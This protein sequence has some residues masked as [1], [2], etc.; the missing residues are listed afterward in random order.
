MPLPA[1]PGGA[2]GSPAGPGRTPLEVA[3]TGLEACDH[4]PL[5]RRRRK[6]FVPATATIS[7]SG[8]RRCCRRSKPRC[9]S[10]TR[11]RECSPP[12]SIRAGQTPNTTS[13]TGPNPARSPERHA[14]WPSPASTSARTRAS[15]PTSGTWRASNPG[16]TYYYR[17]VATNATGTTDRAG[18][19]LLHLSVH[20]GSQRSLRGQC[21]GTAADGG[22]AA[23]RLPRLRARLRGSRGRLRR[24]VDPRPGSDPVRRLSPGRRPAPGPLRGPQRCDPRRP[25]QPDQP[26]CRP[27]RGDPRRQPAGPPP[28]SESRPTT[29]SLRHR[30][31]R[32]WPK[33]IPSLESFAFAGPEICSPCFADGTTGRAPAPAQRQPRP[34]DEG[35]DRTAVPGEDDGLVKKR[36]SAD[37]NHFVFSST[38]Q[39]ELAG[40]DET[41][42]VSIY[43][44]DL[45]RG[46]DPGRLDRTRAATPSPACR[47]P[48][49]ATGRAIPPGSPSSTSP[50][51]ARGSSSARGSPPMKAATT[52]PPLHAPRQLA[53]LG[54]SHPG[55]GRRRPLRR[56][57]RRR[58]ERLP[59]H[60]RQT[61]AATDTDTSADIYE[62]A[63]SGGGALTLR[64]L[65]DRGR[66][67]PATTTAAN[68]RAIPTA[69][70]Q[71]PGR[72][73]AMPSRWPAAPGSAPRDG[74]F[75]FFSPELLD[76]AAQAEGEAN[77]PNLYAVQPGSDPEFVATVD[78]SAT[79]P[80]PKPKG[81]VD[82]QD[83]HIGPGRAGRHSGRPVERRRLRR[84][85]GNAGGRQVHVSGRAADLLRR[86]GLRKQRNTGPLARLTAEKARWRSTTPRRRRPHQSPVRDQ[87]RRI[88]AGLLPQRR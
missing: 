62:A 68:R 54:R 58:D 16:T 60:H 23:Q 20:A 72:A 18:P 9:P 40:N 27:L 53:E 87:Q 45:E 85:A 88:G 39:F 74:T 55:R 83:L 31:P 64:L 7:L 6:R 38:S 65:S 42:D 30:S 49:H 82:T 81:Y 84:P 37:G 41:G 47:E 75:Y 77:Q 70:T 32:P 15:T 33:P 4:L 22:G 86:A 19:A 43:E 10:S 57:D 3:L 1:P 35:V 24:R 63:V 73:N 17:V 52:L 76:G 29:R 34:G 71:P 80:G 79:K 61:A 12:K 44:R 11:A 48:V 67:R 28:M 36:F 8:P 13:N 2:A 69:G 14:R 46:D 50:P 56:H 78:T 59:H 26:R 5:P 21:S 66:R 25:R 51:T